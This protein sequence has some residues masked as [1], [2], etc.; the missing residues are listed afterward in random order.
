MLIQALKELLIDEIDGS[1][2]ELESKKGFQLEAGENWGKIA[3][4]TNFF[5]AFPTLKAQFFR[6]LWPDLNRFRKL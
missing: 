3:F 1:S 6:H 2:D 5:F 4:W